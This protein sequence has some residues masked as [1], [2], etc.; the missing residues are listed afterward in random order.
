MMKNTHEL[1]Q[2]LNQDSRICCQ[3]Q[4]LISMQAYAKGFSLLPKRIVTSRLAGRHSS[5]FRGRGIN[6]EELRAYRIGDEVK[7]IDWKVTLKTGTPHVRAYSEEKDHNVVLL[8]DQTKSMFFSSVDTMKSVVAAE[9]AALCAWQILSDNDRVGALIMAEE[10]QHWF[11]PRR[12]QTNT[13]QMLNQIVTA[14]QALLANLNSHSLPP[15]ML[16]ASI[17][18]LLTQKLTNNVLLVISDF[19]HLTKSTLEKLS[20]LQHNNDVLCIHIADELETRWTPESDM[21][22]SD[23]HLQINVAGEEDRITAYFSKQHQDKTTA[24]TELMAIKSLPL[25]TLDT[26]GQHIQHFINQVNGWDS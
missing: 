19:Y 21:V 3:L 4:R 8:V 25:I 14:N 1:N 15:D 24:L 7:N 5:P 6:F 17:D 11:K 26:S 10:S 16:A 9:I 20:Q 2:A 22:F 18:E 12:G 23:G 13:I